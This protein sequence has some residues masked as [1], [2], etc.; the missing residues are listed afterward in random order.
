[1]LLLGKQHLP[2]GEESPQGSSAATG[3]SNCF[4][5]RANVET[6]SDLDVRVRPALVDAERCFGRWALLCR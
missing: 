5:I 3:H 2:V 4:E 1:M 6:L